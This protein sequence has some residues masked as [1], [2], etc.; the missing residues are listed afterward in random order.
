MGFMQG[1]VSVLSNPEAKLRGGGGLIQQSSLGTWCGGGTDY[2]H[3]Q[4]SNHWIRDDTWSAWD[5]NR[6]KERNRPSLNKEGRRRIK[7]LNLH[8]IKI[9]I[10]VFAKKPSC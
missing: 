10:T 5:E 4:D 2:E 8:Y 6:K 7:K 1:I 3:F 9:C